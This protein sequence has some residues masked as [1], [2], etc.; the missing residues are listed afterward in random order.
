MEKF[1]GFFH[2][3]ESAVMKIAGTWGGGGSNRH[4]EKKQGMEVKR[5]LSA[6]RMD[7]KIQGVTRRVPR[8]S[9]KYYRY[10]VDNLS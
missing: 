10:R 5:N 4:M 8:F 7:A 2:L 9:T 1:P 3:G 6:N